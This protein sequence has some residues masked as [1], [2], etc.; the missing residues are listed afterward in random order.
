VI[1]KPFEDA[2]LLPGR[3]VVHAALVQIVEEIVRISITIFIPG[4]VIFTLFSCTH[5]PPPLRVE[6]EI[7]RPVDPLIQRNL[8]RHLTV[9]TEEIGSR[10]IYDEEKLGAAARY[11]GNEWAAMGL[12]IRRQ[13]YQASGRK[14]FN[15]IAYG[16]KFDPSR[17]AILLGAHYDT[18]PGTPGADDNASAVAVL[19]ETTRLVMSD[20]PESMANILFVAFSTEEPPSFGTGRMGSRAFV[21]ALD[22]LGYTIEGAIILEMVG[23]YD[24]RPHTQRIPQGVDFPGV[25]DTGDFVGIIADGQSAALAERTLAGYRHSGSRLEAVLMIFPEPRGQVATLIRLSDHVSFWD[26]GIPAVMITDTA[27]LRNPSYHR[28]TDRMSTLSI[29]AMEN[30]VYGMTAVLKKENL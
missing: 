17:S 3:G 10:S 28:P 24:H 22:E 5:A 29:P 15:I 26:A 16:K 9:L 27:F 20:S 1:K 8:T 7:L 13:E 2:M 4:F 30:V 6:G 23:Y 25:G 12:R 11:I 19:L 21:G 18:V 14:T